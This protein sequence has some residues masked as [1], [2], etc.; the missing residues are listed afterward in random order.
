MR[1]TADWAEAR[2][3]TRERRRLEAEGGAFR[4]LSPVRLRVGVHRPILP[5]TPAGSL[6]GSV[7]RGD[8]HVMRDEME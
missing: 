5:G 6:A 7:Q 2:R 1:P 3:E 8:E 4:R